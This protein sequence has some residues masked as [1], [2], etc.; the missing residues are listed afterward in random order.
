MALLSSFREESPL[1]RAAIALVGLLVTGVVGQWLLS[2]AF[3]GCRTKFSELQWWLPD[4]GS[5]RGTLVVYGTV[6]D[7]LKFVV[8]PAV[9]L[10]LRCR[11]CQQATGT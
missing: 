7:V 10:W 3:D 2:S 9:L 1:R 5:I 4:A 6:L 8:I 11:Y